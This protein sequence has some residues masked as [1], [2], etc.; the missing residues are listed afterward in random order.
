MNST[1]KSSVPADIDVVLQAA[2]ATYFRGQQPNERK[3][4]A[5][6]TEIKHA[7][8]LG[9]QFKRA[10]ALHLKADNGMEIVA[11]RGTIPSDR[12]DWKNNF[13][14]V[15][16]SALA[17]PLQA[18][19]GKSPKAMRASKYDAAAKIGEAMRG[20]D[21]VFAG[22]SLGGGLAKLAGEVA[23]TPKDGNFQKPAQVF[24]FNGAPVSPSTY[25]YYGCAAKNHLRD[26]TH[27]MNVNDPL[28]RY[29]KGGK[30]RAA[31]GAIIESRAG[32]KSIVIQAMGGGNGPGIAG[33]GLKSFDMS[34]TPGKPLQVTAALKDAAGNA[35]QASEI[36]VDFNRVPIVDPAARAQLMSAGR[37][38]I[39][40]LAKD[41]TLA[42]DA[43][44][45]AQASK[46]NPIPKTRDRSNAIGGR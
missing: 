19:T 33:H 3:I 24:S 9:E 30:I 14:Q 8:E 16:G 39:A 45:L 40:P 44:P 6:F 1:G 25:T 22:H 4:P 20:S 5:G 43:S 15:A 38:P 18:M 41:Q 29:L 46:N 21:V 10:D 11:F 2:E 7:G 17:R 32:G 26:T 37:H 23:S 13:Q 27:V 35:M 34:A 28:N 36:K 31:D 42:Q 12:N